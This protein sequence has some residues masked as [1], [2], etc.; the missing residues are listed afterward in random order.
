MNKIIVDIYTAKKLKNLTAIYEEVAKYLLNKKIIKDESLLI[1]E[2]IER[3][4]LGSIK[5]YKDVYLPHI[6]SENILSNII[7]RVD[8]YDEKILFILIGH[9]EETIKNKIFT[10]INNMLERNYVEEMFSC[11]EEIFIKKINTI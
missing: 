11:E 4:Q 5:I 1:R 3:E 7:L 10:L 6:I 8:G 2:L 9:E